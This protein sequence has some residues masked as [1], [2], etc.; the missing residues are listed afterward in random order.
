MSEEES[1][2]PLA[3]EAKPPISEE[4]SKKLFKW[5]LSLGVLH[6]LTGIV[7][8]IITDT[9]ATAPVYTFFPDPDTRGISDTWAP[10]AK[11]QYNSVVGY[12]SAVSILI[13]AIDH[14][15][16]STL[17]RKPYEY[18]L[19]RNR[20]PFRW[21]E[22]AFSA[23]FMHVMI[24]QLSGVF[25]IHLLFAIF[26][27]TLITMSFGNDQE[28]LNASIPRDGDG[29]Q[30]PVNYRPFLVGWIPHMFGWSIILCFFFVGVSQGDPPGFVWA[31]IFI[32]FILDLSFPINQYLQQA[33]IG[34]WGK[35]VYGEVAF[36][37]LSL[38][39]KQLLAW[40]NFGGTAALNSDA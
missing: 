36:C 3:A 16:V 5:N 19:A 7:I 40:L 29:P 18:Y 37:V 30:K 14:L 24:A 28:E 34:P 32:L 17:L 1:V 22:Y 35:Y 8:C 31:I 27:L 15:L 12:L 11:L 2:E 33:G 26:G 13:A 6:L 25:S 38:V 23:S 9:D 39:S 4:D 21:L 20:N 10:I